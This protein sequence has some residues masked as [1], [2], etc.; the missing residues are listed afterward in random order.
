MSHNNN[1]DSKETSSLKEDETSIK[2][3]IKNLK[4]DMKKELKVLIGTLAQEMKSDM[5]QELNNLKHELPQELERDM[6]TKFTTL[7][8]DI[9]QELNNSFNAFDGPGLI[10]I[11]TPKSVALPSE[12]DIPHKNVAG[13]ASR[14]SYLLKQLLYK[15]R[16]RFKQNV[17]TARSFLEKKAPLSSGYE[18][19]LEE[20]VQFAEKLLE[21]W[22]RFDS[23]CNNNQLTVDFV[24]NTKSLAVMVLSSSVIDTA[25]ALEAKEPPFYTEL[26]IDCRGEAT[27]MKSANLVKVDIG[28]IKS[29]SDW[30]KAFR[31]L[32]I[33][34]AVIERV[35]IACDNEVNYSLNGLAAC[36]GDHSFVPSVPYLTPVRPDAFNIVA[37]DTF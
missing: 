12:T 1:N 17:K 35:I 25:K 23:Q 29:N 6:A 32:S 20:L 15:E 5:K 21:A 11:S 27:F 10:R 7:G 2:E 31:Q 28:E 18:K 13:L 26:E 14:R 37:Q 4:Q 9:K 36:F 8:T 19:N 34:L 24:N 30:S 22:G 16:E 3:Y 33:R